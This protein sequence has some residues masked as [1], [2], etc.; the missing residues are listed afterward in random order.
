[1]QTKV[2]YGYDEAIRD[3]MASVRESAHS[4]HDNVELKSRLLEDKCVEDSTL[5]QPECSGIYTCQGWRSIHI[6]HSP[7]YSY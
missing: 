2:T 3:T 5:Q 1:M 7:M 4:V 6:R